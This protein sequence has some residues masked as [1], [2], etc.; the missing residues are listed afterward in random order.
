MTDDKMRLTEVCD[1][2]AKALRERDYFKSND[3]SGVYLNGHGLSLWLNDQQLMKDVMALCAKVFDRRVEEAM[4]ML[5]ME[6]K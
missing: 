3:W 2:V 4:E 6:V 5:K 1:M